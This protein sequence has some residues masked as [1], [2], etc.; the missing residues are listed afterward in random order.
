MLYFGRL[1]SIIAVFIV[2]ALAIFSGWREVGIDRANYIAM[3]NGVLLSDDFAVKLWYAKD[4]FFLLITS[5]SSYFSEDVRLAFLLI[6]TLSIFLKYI[7]IQKI[8]RKY[9]L[10][11]IAL[12]FLFLAPGLEFA[13]M[14]G[15]LAISFLMLALIYRNRVIP[16]FL[17]SI[18]AISAH[19]SV[20]P[21]VLLSLPC[22]NKA[23]SQ[24]KWMYIGIF[25]AIF[26]S[27]SVLLDLFPR[28]ADYENNRGT[29]FSIS[30]PL[31]TLFIAWLV[32]FR[33]NQRFRSNI[34]N[35]LYKNIVYIR[36]LI[37]GVIAISFGLA[38]F[39]VTAST[40]YLE[41]AWCLLLLASIVMFRKTYFNML[42]F[43]LFI[44]LL[45]YLNIVRSTWL[46]ILNPALFS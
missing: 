39:A 43:G 30:E 24:Y 35:E 34:E 23:L 37:Y 20:M 13:A 41:I 18:L 9:T 7:F 5:I 15:G 38:A 11:F 25:L 16:F 46:A 17:L 28:G 4:I 29:V 40:R 36:Q 31:A 6:C 14:R 27:A 8:S 42:G 10:P 22:V 12:Y 32:F 19:V 26:L 21:V 44:A 33:L 45:I 2:I 1:N 3:Y